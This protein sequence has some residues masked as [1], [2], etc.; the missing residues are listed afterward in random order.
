MSDAQVHNVHRAT[1]ADAVV[2]EAG[3]L[4][5]D[6]RFWIEV[7]ER[8]G[9][10]AFAANYEI[11]AATAVAAIEEAMRRFQEQHPARGLGSYSF[12]RVR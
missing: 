6:R 10:R 12:A 2:R 5:A 7:R 9:P 3:E 8:G 4:V 1:Q 11:D